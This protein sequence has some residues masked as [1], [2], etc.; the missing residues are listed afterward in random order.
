MATP[1]YVTDLL[2]GSVW[3]NS[4][5]GVTLNYKFWTAL[6]SYYSSSDQESV[7]FQAFTVE[8]K[9]A[10]YDIFAQIS[11]FANITFNEVAL[12][13]SAKIGFAQAT[14]DPDAEAWAYYPGGSSFA[15]DVWT[16]STY[17][18][19][20][21]V[22]KGTYEYL[23]L[24]HEIGHALGL[25]HSFE[26]SN[27]LP[28]AEDNSRYTVMSYTNNVH[29]ESYMM[30]DIAALQYLYGANMTYATGNNNYALQSGHVYAIWDAGGTD[31]LDGSALSSALTLN[32]NAGT[33]SSVGMTNNIAIAYNVTIENA[34]GG[35]GSDT[36]YDN[37]ANNFIQG[38]GGN[39][40]IYGGAGNDIFDGGL[41]TDTIVY[42]ANSSAFTFDFTDAL[43][44]IATS[45]FGTDTLKNLENF[46][47]SDGTF[48]LAQ[49][50]AAGGGTGGGGTGGTGGSGDLVL[51]GTAGI[52]TLTGDAGNDTL[53]G[54]GGNDLLYGM[55]GNDVLNGGLNADKMYGGFGDDTYYVDNSSD[56]TYELGGIDSVHSA[57]SHTLAAGLE[58]LIL[59]GTAYKGSGN[60]VANSLTGN[61]YG[62]QLLGAGGND[63]LDGGAGYDLLTGGNG[64]DTFVFHADTA[65][66]NPDKVT[67]FRWAQGDALDISD[68]LT[69]YDP[70]S[71]ALTDFVQITTVGR[72]SVLSVDQDGAGTSFGFAQVATIS[73]VTGLTNEDALAA[74]GNLIVF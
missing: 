33:F 32:L 11:T 68:L 2:S 26:G 64:A 60:S 71:D 52:D 56:R 10:V 1:Y 54:L 59:E 42:A 15:G 17:F 5:A 41:G 61:D 31:A 3:S 21:H 55:D 73:S 69:G 51:N 8:S 40:K 4:G 58:N 70:L 22:Q 48:T 50:Q 43:A 27:S 49:L 24:L 19:P 45:L 6:P 62:N 37:A 53:N 39:D 38:N 30:Y 14:L 28:D 34:L 12:D 47:F 44:I 23:T 16:N 63:L 46:T 36:I 13:S 7:N 65:Y 9:A 57:I 74:A 25:K 66:A 20:Q 18:D 67:D 35:A 29:S 72:N